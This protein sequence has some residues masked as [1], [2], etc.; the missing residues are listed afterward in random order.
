MT[1]DIYFLSDKK[2]KKKIMLSWKTILVIVLVF[3]GFE[4]LFYQ[5]IYNKSPIY[6]VLI[7]VFSLLCGL[8]Y[9]FYNQSK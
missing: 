1:S 3:A 9:W 8:I 5:F 2:D 4:G 7:F 6:S